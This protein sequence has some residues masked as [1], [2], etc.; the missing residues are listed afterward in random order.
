MASLPLVRLYTDG[1]SRGNPGPAAVGVVVCDEPDRILEEHK[2]CIGR[3]T[4]NE[5]E[6]H[7]L[8][9]GLA[10]AAKH[11]QAKVTCILDSEFVVRQVTGKYKATDPRM[12]ELLRQVKA[13]K[14][15][16]EEVR[17]EHRERLTGLLRR[18]DAL[19]NEALDEAGY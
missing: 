8:L 15:A 16:F 18:A 17:L 14:A 7:A 10:L 6:Y 5:A 11:T 1:G 4:N 19:V 2:E 13:R 9:A 12:K 3:A